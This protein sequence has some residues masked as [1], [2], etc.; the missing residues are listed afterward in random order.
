MTLPEVSPTRLAE[1]WAADKDVLA[2]LAEN[3]DIAAIVRPVDV[4]FRGDDDALDKLEQDAAEL[5]FDVIEREEDD[6]GEMCLFLMRE[7]AADEASIKALTLKC[8]QIE[9]AYDV[10]YD[11][12]GC[13]AEDG[14]DEDGTGE[15]GAD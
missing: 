8:L 15:D 14:A 5:G 3:G 7:Q 10:E 13:T 1:E 12:W 9:L 2:S 11:G 6:E 4:S